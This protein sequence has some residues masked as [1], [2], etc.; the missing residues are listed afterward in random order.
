[1]PIIERSPTWY[2][3]RPEGDT[4][5]ITK[6][7]ANIGGLCTDGGNTVY[8]AYGTH[9]QIIMSAMHELGHSHAVEVQLGDSDFKQNV[10]D[11]LSGRNVV[12]FGQEEVMYLK[13]C[14]GNNGSIYS[15]GTAAR[16]VV[17]KI[18]DSVFGS[19]STDGINMEGRSCSELQDKLSN[20]NTS[21]T[22][23]NKNQGIV[24]V[25]SKTGRDSEIPAAVAECVTAHIIE[26]AARE[27]GNPV[28]IVVGKKS[29]TAHQ[30]AQNV[31]SWWLEK[32]CGAEAHKLVFKSD[33]LPG[34]SRID[35]HALQQ[36]TD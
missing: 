21:T 2:K 5:I 11:L 20:M 1:M 26:K 7:R 14:I 19:G 8:V 32:R 31:A 16:G 18:S 22:I 27:Y 30:R 10:A 4:T 34:S 33:K 6:E 17:S 23:G 3:K 13:D 15:L 28:N 29:S 12:N 25:N 24:F 9:S 36:C 35:Q